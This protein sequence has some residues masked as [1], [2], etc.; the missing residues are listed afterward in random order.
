MKQK[1]KSIVA[2]YLLVMS[3]SLL[4]G[5]ASEVLEN[6]FK[7]L[8]TFSSDFEQVIEN[9]QLS[10]VEVSGGQ[11]WISRPGKF[12]WDYT[13][14]F[15]QEIVSDGNKIWIYDADLEQVTVRTVNSALGNT[16]A[17]LLSDDKPLSDTF[18]VQSL[19]ETAG[20]SWVELLPKDSD[21][22]F[23][24]IK[25]AFKGK[26]LSE[27]LLLDNLG[28]ITQLRFSSIKRNPSVDASRFQFKAPTGADIF[29]TSS[30]E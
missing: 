5:D 18:T 29:D 21:A 11:L 8:K 27:M 1:I 6:F 7:G 25:L 28:Q 2:S 3:S 9:S 4:A 16:P 26:D 15:I 19:G 13:K 12:R 24:S 22:G 10:T 20:F 17:V 23:T 30:S 14:P